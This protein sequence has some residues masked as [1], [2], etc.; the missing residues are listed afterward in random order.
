MLLNNSRGLF[1]TCM[2]TKPAWSIE[3]NGVFPVCK[4]LTDYVK[5]CSTCGDRPLAWAKSDVQAVHVKK[6]KDKRM[7]PSA[8]KININTH[9]KKLCQRR[10][11]RLTSC[12]RL[13]ADRNLSMFY[14][15]MFAMFL[16]HG[17]KKFPVHEIV[18]F[19]LGYPDKLCMKSSNS[20]IYT[21]RKQLYNVC[22]EHH[23]PLSSSF[24]YLLIE[25]N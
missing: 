23:F 1:G 5:A 18:S 22:A 19:L 9:K 6:K 14:W 10:A 16:L 3:H 2:S 7:R 12:G 25:C 24:L 8:V 11:Q 13:C 4:D 21:R 20:S 15:I 17:V